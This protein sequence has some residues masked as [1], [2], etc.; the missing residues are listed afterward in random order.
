MRHVWSPA[1]LIPT[2]APVEPFQSP[3]NHTLDLGRINL[4]LSIKRIETIGLLFNIGPTP[5]SKKH[6][7]QEPRT[8]PTYNCVYTNAQQ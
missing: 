7:H 5:V 1:T 3:I 4:L 2:H 6:H 8:T